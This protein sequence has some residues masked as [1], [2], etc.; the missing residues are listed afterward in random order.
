M[1]HGDDGDATDVLDRRAFGKALVCAGAGLALSL[2]TSKAH[3]AGPAFPPDIQ[4]IKDRGQLVVGMTGF[5]SAPFYYLPQPHGDKNGS[6]GIE[7]WDVQLA[8]AIAQVLDVKL[9]IDRQATSFNAVIDDVA[10][11][12]IDIAISKLSVTPKRAVRVL[13]THPTIELRHALLVNRLALVRRVGEEDL[14]S[15][16]NRKFDGV[17]GVIAKSS[18][19]DMA[20]QVFSDADVREFAGWDDVVEAVSHGTV[21]FAYR[22]ELEIKKLMR[23]QPELHLNLRSVLITDIRDSIAAALSYESPQLR[24]ITNT[25]ISRMKKF[26]ANQLLDQYADIFETQ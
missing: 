14:R 13:F 12:K 20:R 17:I 3:A 16:I 4:S 19:A 9:S 25:V 7:G 10:A 15:V 1:S 11:G 22:D 6:S 5:D 24:E 2:G 21:D 18:Y 23:L 8:N 26:D